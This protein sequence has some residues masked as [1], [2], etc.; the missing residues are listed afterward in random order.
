MPSS[1]KPRSSK[2]RNESRLMLLHGYSPANPSDRQN[3]I[4]SRQPLCVCDVT[5]TSTLVCIE[6]PD[7]RH[8]KQKDF[9]YTYIQTVRLFLTPVAETVSYTR[10]LPSTHCVKSWVGLACSSGQV[11]SA[12][13]DRRCSLIAVFAFIMYS[14]PLRP[15][16]SQCI[17]H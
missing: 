1:G 14:M 9:N 4:T 5:V 15:M 6:H 10:Y 11:W 12:R 8:R 2:L 17:F 3:C 16:T 13:H 7:K